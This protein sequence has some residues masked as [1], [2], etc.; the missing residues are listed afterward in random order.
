MDNS[1]HHDRREP[2]TR[3]SSSEI[4]HGVFV[5]I[6]GLG[7]LIIGESG[8][9]K[10]ECAL[11]LVAK[12]HSLVADDVVEFKRFGDCI[13]GKSPKRFEGL[14]EVR[15]LGIIDVKRLFGDAYFQTEQHLDLCIRFSDRQ[16][17]ETLEMTSDKRSEFAILGITIPFFELSNV[18]CRNLPLLVETVVKIFRTP[19]G[20][21][22]TDIAAA[23][24]RIVSAPVFSGKALRQT[25]L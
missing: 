12:G 7:V 17:L 20:L 2:E 3:G 19:S 23:H 25:A 4:A 24:D 15:G 1:R 10:S 18:K 21:C 16:F 8:T 9:R 14:L 5:A 6:T 13:I 22:Q 11:D